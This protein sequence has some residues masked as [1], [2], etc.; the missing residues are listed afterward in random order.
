MTSWREGLVEADHLKG[1]IL[2]TQ[3]IIN[4]VPLSQV[5]SLFNRSEVPNEV[6]Y[7]VSGLQYSKLNKYRLRVDEE[8]KISFKFA[9]QSG[10]ARVGWTPHKDVKVIS[11]T[12][13]L[14]AIKIKG[15]IKNTHLDILYYSQD[16]IELGFRRFYIGN[17]L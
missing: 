4:K 3:L 14:I 7:S 8:V 10:V 9:P 2:V 16:G 6:I 1:S 12:P 11:Y 13:T 5:L 15:P 17:A